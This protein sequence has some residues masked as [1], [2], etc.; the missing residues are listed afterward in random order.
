LSDLELLRFKRVEVL[1][2]LLS[3]VLAV[4][5]AGVVVERL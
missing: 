2:V 5:E 1:V 4:V 3:L